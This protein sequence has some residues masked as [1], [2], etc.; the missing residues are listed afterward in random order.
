MT[1][2]GYIYVR[3]WDGNNGG[4]YAV[5]EVSKIDKTDPEVTGATPTTNSVSITATDEASGIKGY[6]I[7]EN[8]I[9]SI[10][11]SMPFQTVEK[12]L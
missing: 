11:R 3:I 7:T 6:K 10:R 8:G 5:G 9:L 2:N 1:E 12:V 4:S